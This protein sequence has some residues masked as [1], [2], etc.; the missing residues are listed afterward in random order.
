MCEGNGGRRETFERMPPAP[1]DSAGESSDGFRTKGSGEEEVGGG[2]EGG[3]GEKE[4]RICHSCEAHGG[5]WISPCRYVCVCLCF[6]VGLSV[7]R[8]WMSASDAW[9]DA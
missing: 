5:G 2:A 3:E 7:R 6:R 8:A 4:C 1:Q 9:F